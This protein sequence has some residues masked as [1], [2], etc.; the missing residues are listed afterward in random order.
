MSSHIIQV[1]GKPMFQSDKYPD[2]EPNHIV[3]SFDDPAARRAL[4][5]LC[6]VTKDRALAEDIRNVLLGY[7]GA[8][9]DP[10]ERHRHERG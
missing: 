3:L 2:L 10:P 8:K 9:H 1:D 5:K 4:W 6:D 7:I